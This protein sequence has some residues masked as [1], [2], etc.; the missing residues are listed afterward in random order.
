[1]QRDI[2]ITVKIDDLT[3]FS[4]R[5]A[6]DEEER[7]R[8]AQRIVNYLYDSWK[9]KMGNL[10]TAELMGRIAFHIARRFEDLN[11]MMAMGENELTRGEEALDKILLDME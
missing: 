11:A 7:A 9:G 5:V 2:N 4:I 10:S 1:M 6:A 3:P 8:E